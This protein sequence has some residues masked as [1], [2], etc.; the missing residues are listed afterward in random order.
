VAF[1]RIPRVLDPRSGREV[2]APDDLVDWLSRHPDLRAGA[3]V[4]TTIA[5]FAAT[6]IDTRVAFD[7]PAVPSVE[8]R[9]NFMTEC[10]QLA[11]LFHF[12][13]GSR[14][15]WYVLDGGPEP[16]A[17]TVIGFDQAAYQRAL[18]RTWPILASLRIDR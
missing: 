6:R 17:V 7:R 9:R 12:S 5:G 16:F 8:C 14:V 18:E 3:P 13:D 1:D 15:R 2:A 11:P 10:T 4:R